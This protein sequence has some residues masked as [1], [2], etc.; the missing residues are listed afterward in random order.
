VTKALKPGDAVEWQTSQ[1]KT[2]G[3]VKRKLTSMSKIK[4]RVGAASKGNPQYLVESKKSG[5]VAAHKS[6]ALKRRSK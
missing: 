4:T 3:T 1:G 6:S 2:Q 5:G